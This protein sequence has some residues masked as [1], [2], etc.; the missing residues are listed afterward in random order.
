MRTAAFASRNAKEILRDPLSYVFCLGFP[1][2]MLLVFRLLNN[3]TQNVN[4]V[5]ALP[6]L[7]SGITVFSFSFTMLYMALLVSKDRS[8]SFL[9]RLYASP[10]TQTEYVLGYLIPGAVIAAGQAV[11]CLLAA[12]LLGLLCGG[13]ISLWR[14]FLQIAALIPV[15]LMNV[16]LGI[17][18]GSLLSEKAAPGIA[19]ILISGSGFLSGAWMPVDQMGRFE[20]IC[21]C[22][23]FYPAVSLGRAVLAGTPEGFH[24]VGLNLATT[25]IYALAALLFAICAFRHAMQSHQ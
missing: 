2:V 15:L 3:V 9:T 13:G 19:S 5:F 6:Y 14:G 10:M 1:V 25:C 18:F 7:T 21:R 11:V 22:L 20:T 4:P 12:W 16:C 17:A 23:P 8:T 24:G